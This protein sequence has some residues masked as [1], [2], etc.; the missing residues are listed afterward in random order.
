MA[1]L[2]RIYTIPLRRGTIK[3]PRTNRAKKA[4]A[5][6]RTYIERHMKS[7]DISISNEL[8]ELVWSQGMRN[9]IMK[10]TVMAT[11]DDKNK[12]IVKLATETLEASKKSEE[13]TVKHATEKA[14]ATKA[15]IAVS[16]DANANKHVGKAATPAKDVPHKSQPKPDFEVNEST[17]K[18]SADKTLSGAPHKA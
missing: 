15:A 10:V 7:T 1:T 13:R 17:T 6:L 18:P 16:K 3:S 9:P 12:V 5:V 4:V 2:E 14:T 11:K 8:N